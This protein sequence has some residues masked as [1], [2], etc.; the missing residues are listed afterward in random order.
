MVSQSVGLVEGVGA[1]G[2][3]SIRGHTVA[4]HLHNR[5]CALV[6]CDTLRTRLLQNSHGLPLIQQQ[7]L[8]RRAKPAVVDLDEDLV[9]R[10]LGDRQ[11]ADFRARSLAGADFDC[12][13]LRAGER[14]CG[15]GD[16]GG[17]GSSDGHRGGIDY[18]AGLCRKEGYADG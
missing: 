16:G 13:F 3:A 15:Y 1:L 9:G 10:R 5:P 11:F 8:V 4:S 14:H 17:A 18:I 6:S 7:T 12:S 2:S